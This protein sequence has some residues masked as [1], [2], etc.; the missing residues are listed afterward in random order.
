[1]SGVSPDM[2]DIEKAAAAGNAR[3]RLAID[4]F[5]EAIRHYIGAF[6]V[7]AYQEILGD[8]HNLFGDTNAVHVRLSPSGPASA[9]PFPVTKPL[10]DRLQSSSATEVY[11]TGRASREP[12]A[13]RPRKVDARDYGEGLPRLLSINA[14]LAIV[15]IGAVI[16]AVRYLT[17]PLTRG[18]GDDQRHK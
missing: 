3:A 18:N 6:L 5:V 8:L 15:V 11:A 9:V 2:R 12:P 13:A 14:D 10:P 1:M 17:A 16:P 7:G 4:V